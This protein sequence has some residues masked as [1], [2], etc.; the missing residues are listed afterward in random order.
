MF[1][2]YNGYDRKRG[3]YIEN[4]HGDI[5]D[6]K[7]LVGCY[8]RYLGERETSHVGDTLELHEINLEELDGTKPPLE[9]VKVIEVWKYELDENSK[10][11]FWRKPKQEEQE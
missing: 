5:N 3:W 8:I 11:R 2:I 10:I 4:W 1:C 7:D 6:M 9:F